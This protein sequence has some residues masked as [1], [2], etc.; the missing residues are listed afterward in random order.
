MLSAAI[1]YQVLSQESPQTIEKVKAVLEKHPWYADRWHTRL[2]NVPVAERDQVLF[3]QAVA[4]RRA[5]S[6]LTETRRAGFSVRTA[7]RG[8]GF[9]SALLPYLTDVEIAQ[10]SLIC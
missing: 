6:S 10:L 2:Q 8:T 1:A 3:M 4:A 7:G 5:K 9:T